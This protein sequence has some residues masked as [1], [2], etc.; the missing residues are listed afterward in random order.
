MDKPIRFEAGSKLTEEEKKEIYRELKDSYKV[1]QRPYTEEND[2]IVW[3]DDASDYM[4]KSDITGRLLRWYIY[5]PDGRIAHPTEVFG[6]SISVSEIDR[7]QKNIEYHERQADLRYNELVKLLKEKNE[8]GK[9]VEGINLAI[10]NGAKLKKQFDSNDIGQKNAFVRLIFNNGIDRSVP[11]YLINKGDTYL[12]IDKQELIRIRVEGLKNKYLNHILSEIDWERFYNEFNITQPEEMEKHTY[13]LTLRPFDIGTYPKQDFVRFVEE[14]ADNYKFGLLEYSSE[15]PI[16]TINHFSLAPVSDLMKYD[17]K[18]YY[19]YEDIKAKINVIKDEN[20]IPSA[21]ITEF[22]ENNEVVQ[23]YELNGKDFL[24]KIKKLNYRFIGDSELEKGIA[25]EQ[26][27]K[28]TLEKVASGE[29]SV[30]EILN[31]LNTKLSK[32]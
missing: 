3:L 19:Y 32:K 26:E 6:A 8:I 20:N 29:I 10:E 15:L 30:D 7:V 14:E 28:D 4:T 1:N 31:F 2:K 27:H 13:A 9:V 16:E 22:D 12:G 23:E 11:E 17:G 21:K 25:V 5:L 18:E 24:Q